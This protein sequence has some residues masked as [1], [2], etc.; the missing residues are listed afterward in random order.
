MKNFGEQFLSQKDTKL[1]TS[2]PVEYEAERRKI[3]EDYKDKKEKEILLQKPADK[4]EP[5]KDKEK[6]EQLSQKPADKI[7]NWLEVIEKTHLGHQDDPRVIDRIKEFY[8]KENVIKAEDIPEAT[9]LLE[10]KIARELGHG[11][12][13]ITDEF[14]Q[15]KTNEIINNQK[16]SLDKW[17]NYL[18]SANAQY[19]MWAKYWTF[20]SVLSM[21][22]LEKKED[23][24]TK[25]ELVQFKRRTKDTVASFPPL[26]PRAL[27]LTIGSISNKAENNLKNTKEEKEKIENKS[28]RLNAVEFK[29]LLNSE[30]FSKIYAQFLKEIPEYSTDGLKETRGKWVIYKQGSEPDELVKSLDGHPL[31]WCTADADTAKTQLQGGD[32]HV[33]YSNN[34]DGEAVIPR[35]AIRM[36]EDKIA[37]VRGIAPSQNMDPY[38]NDIVKEKMAKFPDSKEYEKKSADM[39]RLTEVETKIKKGETLSKEDI[40]FLYEI[41]S[42]IQG[43]GFED[44]PR[45]IELI[46]SRDIKEDI[47]FALGYSKDDISL[48]S[49]KS[50]NVTLGETLNC[51]NKYHYGDLFV[52]CTTAKGLKFSETMKGDLSFNELT[53]ADG[54]VLPKVINGNLY[55][56]FLKDA[57]NL[58]LPRIVTGDLNLMDLESAENLQLPEVVGSLNLRGLKSAR[59]LKLPQSFNGD[60]LLDGL[61]TIDGLKLPPSY[62]G[63]LYLSGLN[64]KEK[65]KLISKKY[66]FFGNK[67]YDFSIV[68]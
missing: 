31:E 63:K 54:L 60:L 24:D 57:N 13:E 1:H 5:E 55:L 8:Y 4:V 6:K 62:S 26:N 59:G 27:A 65:Q 34:E 48:T 58:R 14:R 67:N 22:K 64:N 40:K 29:E 32:F 68:R 41:D 33:Y 36:E 20:K 47:S 38:I 43:F 56:Y 61:A 53:S 3:K 16:R 35:V 10:Q 46:D 49:P 37:E 7:A 42:K 25:A 50:L 52:E 44:D 39:K 12:V 30:N 51:G 19:P 15:K 21:G 2:Q 66:S 18:S 9:F 45:I 23:P 11:T 28:K 17:I